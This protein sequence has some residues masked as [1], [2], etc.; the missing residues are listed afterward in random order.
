MG[1]YGPYVV[2]KCAR[3]LNPRAGAIIQRA[4]LVLTNPTEETF[5]LEDI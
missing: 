1:N 4:D 3:V 5:H 2:G